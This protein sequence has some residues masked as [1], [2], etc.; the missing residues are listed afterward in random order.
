MDHSVWRVHGNPLPVW[1]MVSDTEV[2]EVIHTELPPMISESRLGQSPLA[3]HTAR[4]H[5]SM[6]P[7]AGGHSAELPFVECGQ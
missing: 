6:S 7:I 4:S 3:I 1:P 2:S 5:S